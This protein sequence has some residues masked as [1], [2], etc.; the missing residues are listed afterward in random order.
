MKRGAAAILPKLHGSF[1]K[2]HGTFM[3]QGAAAHTLRAVLETQPG[4][5]Q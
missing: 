3:R 5:P 1:A 4:E 2:L